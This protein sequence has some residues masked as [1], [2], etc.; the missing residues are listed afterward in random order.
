MMQKKWWLMGLMG[1]IALAGSVAA[2]L[3]DMSQILLTNGSI[4]IRTGRMAYPS[5][6]EAPEGYGGYYLIHFADR[7]EPAWRTEL[8]SVARILE[9]I[10]H[11]TYLVQ[12]HSGRESD[13]EE[14]SSA[15]WTGLYLPYFK[16]DREITRAAVPGEPVRIRISLFP[17][18]P[19]ETAEAVIVRHGGTVLNRVYQPHRGRISCDIPFGGLDTVLRELA[20]LPE[21]EWI[22]A[23]P[24]YD[25]CNDTTRWLCQSGPYSSGL[26]PLYDH[27]IFGEGQ[28][29]GIMDTGCDADMCF[30]Y[31]SDEGIIIPNGGLNLNQRKI[32]AYIG[33]A[34]YASSYDIQG[35]GTHT[36]GTVAGDDFATPGGYDNGDGIAP[37]AR[38]IIQD[39]GDSWDVYPPDDET[40]AHQ[41]I[42]D[43]GGR[44]HSNS[45]G[46]PSSHGV[47]HDDS[48]EVDQFIWNNPDYSI[49]YAAGND[50][51]S[52]DTIR[53][54]GTAKNCI[55]VGATEHGTANLENNMYFSSHG[56]TNDGRRKPDVTL[57][58]GEVNSA[59]CDDNPGTFNCSTR[60]SDGT[61]MA[62]PGVAGSAALVRDYF[63]QG[64]YPLGTADPG[65]AFEP[66]SA[67]VKAVIV[68]SGI[69]MTGG[70]TADS[71][72][73]HADIPSMGQGW[74]RVTL[75]TALHFQGET[76]SLFIDDNT[77]GISSP[78]DSIDYHVSVSEASEMLEITLVWTDYPSNPQ[79]SLNLV[80]DLDL[81]VTGNGQ[82]CYGNVYSGGHSVPGGSYD[83]L[84]NTECVQIDNPG[85]GA[86]TITVAGYNIPMGPQPFALVV[87]GALS[88]SDGIVS[89]DRQTYTCASTAII[90]VSDADL[91]GVGTQDVTVVSTT[92]PVGETVT[93]D[94]VGSDT[95]F[96]QGSVVTTPVDPAPGEVQVADGDILTV[97]YIDADDG[98]GGVNVPK[99][100]GAGIDCVGPVISDVQIASV[101]ATQARITFVTDEI[102]TGKIWYGES[103]PPSEIAVEGESGTAHSIDISDL[104]DCTVYLFWVEAEDAAGNATLDDNSGTYYQFITLELVVILD[105]NMDTDPGWSVGG[106]WA[107]GQPT[108]GSGDHGEPD[109]TSG[110]TGSNVYGYN[111]NGGYPDNMPD[112]LYLTT[113]A[114]DCTGGAGTTLGFW[115]WLGVEQNLYDHASIQ[116]STN[117]ATWTDVWT[118]PAA[119]LDGGLWEYWEFDLSAT[120]DGQPAVYLRWGMGPTDGGWTYCGWN[121]DD[122]LVSYQIECNPI[123]PTPP[124]TQTPVQPT[125]TPA[126]PT[127]TPVTPTQTAV[128]P[129][130]TPPSSPTSPTPSPTDTPPPSSTPSPTPVDPTQ[131]P[132]PPTG[133]PTPT[134]PATGS[135]CDLNRSHY[136]PGDPF[137]LTIRYCNGTEDYMIVD[138]YLVLDVCGYFYFWPSWEVGPDAARRTIPPWSSLEETIFDFIWPAHCGSGEG[139]F[140]VAMLDPGSLQLLGDYG[141]CEFGWSEN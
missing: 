47:Y 78:G 138:G 58:G 112:T 16:V 134:C 36:A 13:L 83:R 81:T 116:I 88:F 32:I 59:N 122:I 40:T 119:T 26:T 4:D 115:C 27:G 31:D 2:E 30:F 65:F 1:S 108:G 106:Q 75:D 23:Y 130:D 94:E 6:W 50:G 125:D 18:E 43:L 17:G 104:S 68:N 25:L 107:W 132:V 14:I 63:M 97:T 5:G 103:Y 51:S 96:F 86:Y 136:R 84:N 123:T 44:I 91:A 34:N 101:T 66:S 139:R 85:L 24:D 118:N 92:D 53:A 48:M 46:W 11:N 54:P 77:A 49:V 28:I 70:Y 95:G 20:F 22:Q 110:Y 12:S 15:D 73:G 137:R 21:V 61:S 67:L 79:A 71:G 69:N 120:A 55:T 102:S 19:F 141:M 41:D 39:Y 87:S 135:E 35:H 90:S 38:L 76:R 133:S 140:W 33:P 60:T 29:V 56:P 7:I 113:D 64:F 42:Y 127:Q 9:Y 8:E 72:S 62:C 117:G 131:T 109:P 89:F 10:P 45:W 37:L 129:T 121:L 99:T 128:P 57:P 52:S 3:S 82:T 105:E 114:F 126:Q 111:L 80:N 100:D 74:G 98:H 93:L 124:P